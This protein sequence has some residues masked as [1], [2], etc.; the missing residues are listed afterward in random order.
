MRE[1]HFGLEDLLDSELKTIVD[2]ESR[3]RGVYE[4]FPL[5]I[6]LLFKLNYCRGEV[7]DVTTDIGIFQSF[8]FTHYAQAPYTLWS[9]YSLYEKGYYLES[10]IL[11]RN[12]LEAFIQMRYFHKYPQKLTDHIT[13]DTRIRFITMFDEFSKGFYKITY[14]EILSGASHSM[15]WKDVFR[16]VRD[17]QTKDRVVMGCEYNEDHATMVVNFLTPI[18]YGLLNLFPTVFSKNTLKENADFGVNIQKH[19][20]WLERSMEQL[21]QVN[22][23]SVAWYEMFDKIIKQI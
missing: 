1:H 12:L 9:I 22:P 2:T 21:K 18:F 5:I 4:E 8:C 13:G 6:D 16:V 7:E 19:M 14:G 11:Y 20:E 10:I 23:K 15:V 17:S 3:L